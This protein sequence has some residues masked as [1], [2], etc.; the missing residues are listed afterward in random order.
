MP[1]G[2]LGRLSSSLRSKGVAP[3]KFKMKADTM[4]SLAGTGQML[5]NASSL[6]TSPLTH[7]AKLSVVNSWWNIVILQDCDR[8]HECADIFVLP[9][10]V[11]STKTCFWSN[12][13]QCLRDPCPPTVV[14]Y[15]PPK[16][17]PLSQVFSTKPIC[18]DPTCSFHQNLFLV[19]LVTVAQSSRPSK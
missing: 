19:K 6:D 2:G 15:P 5:A 7:T 9:R 11:A 8:E 16:K 3:G 18:D 17:N 10:P 4:N 12:W 13:S 14:D 1:L